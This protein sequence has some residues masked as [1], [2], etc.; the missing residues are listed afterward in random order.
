MYSYIYSYNIMLIW[1]NDY[2]MYVIC[3]YKCKAADLIL[4]QICGEYSCID[5]S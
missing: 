1:N 2:S 5:S 3:Q 4:L